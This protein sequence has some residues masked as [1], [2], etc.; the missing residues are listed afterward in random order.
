LVFLGAVVAG[1]LL[2]M[3]PI[4]AAEGGG[5]PLRIAVFTATSALSVTGLA[6]V[7]TA[8]YWST[9]GECV[10][11]VLM[12]LGGLGIM[13]AASL[14][15]LLVARRLGLRTR[16]LVQTETSSP[17]MGS[18]R[19]LLASV[20]RISLAIE[21][22]A[23]LAI[24]LRLVLKYEEPVG[25][26]SYLGLFHAVSAYNN[27]GLALWPNSLA[28]FG[29][30]AL[31]L[32]PI[33]L[34]MILGAL[35]YPVLLE[36]LHQRRISRWSLHTRLTLLTFLIVTVTGL[37][38]LIALE[39][40]NAASLG[41]HGGGSGELTA[42]IFS[43][44][45]AGTAGFNVIDYSQIEPPARLVTEVLMYIGGGSGGTAGGIK[46]TTLAVLVLA[47]VAEARGDTD[48]QVFGRRL[49]TSTVRQALSVAVLFMTGILGGTLAV[50]SLS[51]ADFDSALFEVV[52][53]FSSSG[54]STGITPDLPSPAQYVLTML[55]ILGR[56][57]PITIATSLALRS[58][59]R[60]YRYPES[61]PLVG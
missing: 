45:T 5:T 6:V 42:G 22:F 56:I 28:R 54:L 13:T 58:T 41:I 38:L 50:L 20:L 31:L 19:R 60:L 3:L 9:F 1:T 32:A 36:V 55:M 18:V 51:T 52:S 27:G 10:Q 43:G 34:A 25:R 2:L 23:W 24:T 46:L 48:I 37:V 49:A 17:D 40:N 26:A 16:M 15:G 44:I 53:A 39:W 11:L 35:G 29:S 47:V 30:D 21:V 59:P 12:Q 14:L 4:A 7:D 8:S 61:R 33:G 57:G